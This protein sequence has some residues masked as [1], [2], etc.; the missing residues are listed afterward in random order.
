MKYTGKNIKNFIDV[1]M[2]FLFFILILILVNI[3]SV[4]ISFFLKLR[5]Y[6]ASN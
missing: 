2:T 6:N 5:N 4:F 1:F 3:I